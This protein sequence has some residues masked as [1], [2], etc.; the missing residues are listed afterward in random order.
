M[1]IILDIYRGFP[2]LANMNRNKAK[3][4]SPSKSVAEVRR[5]ARKKQTVNYKALQDVKIE[6]IDSDSDSI[7]EVTPPPSKKNRKSPKAK[8]VVTEESDGPCGNCQN[9]RRPP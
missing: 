8:K 9:C 2:S 1:S 3:S 5:T 6:T 7:E 4:S